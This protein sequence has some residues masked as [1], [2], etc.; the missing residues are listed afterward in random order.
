M[1]Y[2]DARYLKSKM[3]EAS[4]EGLSFNLPDA[5]PDEGIFVVDTADLF[6]AL[7]GEGAAN[8]RSLERICKHLQIPTQYLHNAGNDAHVGLSKLYL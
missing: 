8:I 7:E 5:T 4:L 6:A 3:I 1:S 2:Q